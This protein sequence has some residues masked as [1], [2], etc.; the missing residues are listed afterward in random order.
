[1]KI[2]AVTVTYNSS[3]VIDGFLESFSLQ[4]YPGLSLYIVDN[5]SGD[6][7]L[8]KVKARS[9]SNVR[10]IANTDNLGIAEAN[11]Q[12]ARRAMDDGCDA[13]LIINNDTEFEAELVEKLVA[14][15]HQYSC[16]IVAPQIV[17]HERPQVIWS[18]GGG[19][20]PHRGY[21]AFHYGLEEIDSGQY[22]NPRQVQ[23]APACCLLIKKEVFERVG[24]FDEKY[25]VY[26]DDSDFTYRAMR[27]G[28]RLMYLPSAVVLHKASTLTGGPES[29]FSLRYRTRNQV[30]FMLKHLGPWK[31][32]YFIPAYQVYVV[33]QS[34]RRTSQKSVFWLRE[35]ALFEGL[36]LWRASLSS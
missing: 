10:V 24:L 11:N 14:G 22:D 8:R 4:S 35:K 21:A 9:R 16:D 13:I 5:A 12:G 7:T 28:M 29:E 30:Y 20:R 2:G 33:L 27:A 19:F 1:M 15:L 17:F 6:D 36:Q 25:F 31:S 23:H 34:W 26:L 18:A 32:L 3:A